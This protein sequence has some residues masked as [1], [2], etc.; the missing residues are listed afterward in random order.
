[1][2]LSGSVA[3]ISS[4]SKIITLGFAKSNQDGQTLQLPIRSYPLNSL[5]QNLELLTP[6]ESSG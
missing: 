3:L 5:F 4:N 6:Q 2:I 1:M